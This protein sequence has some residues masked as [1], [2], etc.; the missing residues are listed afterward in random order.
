MAGFITL[1]AD[2]PEKEWSSAN[3]VF[4][5]FLD[6]VMD[7]MSEDPKAVQEL[8]VCKFNQSVDLDDLAQ[9]NPDMYKRILAAFELSCSQIAGGSFPVSVNGNELDDQS[10]DQ[11][12]KAIH[13]L[14]ELLPGARDNED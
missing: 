12:R 8:T 7:V 14:S 6:H 1:E 9:H 3:W 5:G 10:Q 4:V 2:V 11:Y 13:R